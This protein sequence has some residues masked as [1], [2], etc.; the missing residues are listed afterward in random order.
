[1]NRRAFLAAVGT[2]A[3]AGC[4]GDSSGTPL[5]DIDGLDGLGA[6]TRTCDEGVANEGT[7][8][9]DGRDVSIE[10]TVVGD[11]ICAEPT[12]QVLTGSGDAAGEVTIVIEASVPGDRDC[13]KCH[14][15][16]DYEGSVRLDAKPE[17]LTL[18]HVTVDG[19]QTEVA[20]VTTLETGMETALETA[21]R[22][23]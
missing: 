16:I 11:S 22:D 5:V 17:V 20:R 6:T 4:G 15:R 19:A 18:E 7:A 12:G 23:R 3:L 14:T 8:T 9:L 13:Q 10:G 2:T 1:M 21:T